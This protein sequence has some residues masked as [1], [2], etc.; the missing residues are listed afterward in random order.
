MGEAELSFGWRSAALGGA[1]VQLL[2]LAVALVLSEGN[3]T[4]NRLLSA[5]LLVFAGL[6]TPYA[7][8]FAGF[9]DAWRGLTFLPVAVPLAAGPLLWA[10]VS[11]IDNGRPPAR[12]GLH[13]FPPALQFTYTFVCFLLPLNIKWAWFT[14]G[15]S[16]W[17][18]PATELAVLFSLI[19]YAGA[20][21]VVLRRRR[22]RLAEARS[23]DDRFAARWLG[24]VLAAIVAA[25][26][27]HLGFGLWS[28]L[29]GGINYFQQTGHYLAIAGIG[30][31]LGAAGWRHSALPVPLPV[32]AGSSEPAT[33]KEDRG[34]PD[35]PA[36]A[37]VIER[38][39]REGGWWREPDLSLPRL[40]RRLGTNTGRLS[41]AINLGLGQNFSTFINGLRAEAVADALRVQ[42]R[43]DLLDL[44]FEMGFA[45]KASFNRAFRARYGMTPSQ[46]RLRQSAAA[47]SN[48]DSLTRDAILRREFD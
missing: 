18:D 43:R 8:G 14:G 23:D 47:V 5:L 1:V 46:Y 21:S 30:L 4:A 15:H 40:A 26:A 33:G 39:T 13:L 28:A 27:L 32:P 35:W 10:Y 16:A 48:S 22:A 44:A 25:L 19:G 41:R 2:L 38:R 29:V 37:H 17:I 20:I 11:A 7:I 45:S 31:W 42:P 3:R 6:L 34:T 24:G 12:L 9:Y 36:E